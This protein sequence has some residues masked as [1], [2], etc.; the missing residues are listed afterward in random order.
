[1]STPP[2]AGKGRPRG[3]GG[4]GWRAFFQHSATPVFVIGKGRR[5][6]FANAAWEKLTGI[7]LSEA[8]GMACS[9]KRTGTALQAALAP[10]P[11]ALAGRADRARRPAPPA[12]NG[13]PWWDITFAP[14]AGESGVFGVVGFI[15]VVGA[16][17][18]AAAKRVPA[19]VAELRAA[20]AA[21]FA[22]DL[23]DGPAR[24]TAHFVSQARLAAQV[25]APLWLVGERGSGKETAARAIHHSGPN[26]ES[27]FVAID[28]AGLQPYLIESALFG[29]GGVAASERVG[30]LYLK[31]PTALPRDLQQKLADHAAAHP[32]LRLACGSEHT[33]ASAVSGG[34]LVPV[35]Q[36]ALSALEL[37]VPPLRERLD[38][39]PR[40]AARAVPGRALDPAA[41][42]VLQAHKWPG[43]L[44]ELTDVLT[45]AA[46][47]APDGPILREH[48]P[49][50][51]RVK[52]DAPRAAPAKP[53]ELDAILEA[54]EKRLV[55]LALAKTNQN[56]TDAAAL[57]GVFRARLARRIE[58]LGLAPKKPEGGAP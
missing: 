29:L 23:L 43:N 25:L 15:Q 18:P 27:A 51:M 50:V 37:L 46:A 17:V 55:A 10:T 4:F 45:D 24:A 8:L 16:P 52:A 49:L 41:L 5:L 13:P 47:R 38:D 44:R 19:S 3:S 53:L 35:F 48:L 6:R 36:T 42:A 28:C 54:V 26:R 14:L 32:Q 33:A 58:A 1:M 9:A 20:R 57:L 11:E 34:A 12:K 40:L 22:L 7:A 39:L 56:Q 21:H 31:E 2:N 30:T